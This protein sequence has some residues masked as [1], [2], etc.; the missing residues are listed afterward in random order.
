MGLPKLTDAISLLSIDH[1]TVSAP[2]GCGKTHLVAEAIAANTDA[3]PLLVLTHTNAGVAALKARASKLGVRQSSAR[4]TTIDGWSLK[5][6]RSFPTRSR[7]PQSHLELRDKKADYPA[8]RTGALNILLDGHIDQILKSTYSRLIVDEYQDC[9]PE[10]HKLVVGLSK[11]LPTCVLGD[12]LQSIFGFAPG[13]T[14]DWEKDVLSEFPPAGELDVPWRWKLAGN[15]VLGQWLLVVRQQLLNDGKIDMRSAPDCVQ[16]TQLTGHDDWPK[17]LAAANTRPPDGTGGSLIMAKWP[18]EQADY[19]RM[20]PGASKVETADM[21]E[22]QEFAASFLP[23]SENASGMLVA[24]AQSVMTG[25]DPAQLSQRLKSIQSGRNR[26]PPTGSEQAILDFASGPD[27]QKAARVLSEFSRTA[28]TRIFR[29]ELL[30]SA[31]M[32]L[33]AAGAGNDQAL[34][35]LA[36]SIRDRARVTGRYIPKKAVGSTL[37]FKGLEADVSIIL[38]ADTMNARDLYVALTRGTK[39]LVVCSSKRMLP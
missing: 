13:G 25:I 39:K 36:V 1:G 24:F 17:Q 19:A 2:A 32:A 4:I 38:N 34:T 8:I 28:G 27:H 30:R 35:E 5:L 16:W 14:V 22:L 18:S 23:A 10:Q 3:L 11:L 20:I 21:T 15:D 37:L 6:I 31:I 29:S 33:N 12:P 26:N 9:Q 7:I